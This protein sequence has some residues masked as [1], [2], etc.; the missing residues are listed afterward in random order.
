MAASLENVL[1]QLLIP[2][3]SI[4]QQATQQIKEAFKDPSVVPA[5]TEVLATSADP[6]VRNYAGVLLRR[7]IAK[8][9]QWKAL[10]QEIRHTIKQNILQVLIQE[11]EKQVRNS[12]AQVIG[13]VAK[14]ELD[15][16][17]WPELFQF[18][19][20]YVGC[21]ENPLYRE[22]GMFVLS[23]VTG[24]ADDKLKPQLI[25]LATL[26]SKTLEDSQNPMVPYYSVLALT[27]LVAN[28]GTEEVGKYQVLIPKVL[29]VIAHLLHTDED[30][31][32]EALE[33]FDEL[34]ECDVSIVG[35]HVK[36]IVEFCIQISVNAQYGD[37]IRVKAMSFMCWLTRLKKKAILKHKLVSPIIEAVFPVMCCPPVDNADD[38]D[39]DDDD[40]EEG[41]AS[42]A[43]QV[44]DTLA[45]HIPPEKVLPKVL[46]LVQPAL[47][48]S[49]PYHRKAAYLAMAVMAEGCSEN[50]RNKYLTTVVQCLHRGMQDPSQLVQE[51]ALFSLGQFSEHLEPDICKFAPEILP[52]LFASLEQPRALEKKQSISILSKTYYALEMFCENMGKDILPYLSKLMERLLLNLSPDGSK[53][54][55]ELTISAIAAISNA[56]KTDF[57]PYF[58]A[59]V[60]KLKV[61]LM[62]PHSDEYLPLKIQAIDTLGVLARTVGEPFLPLADEC[63]HLGLKLVDE[64]PDPDLRRCVYGLFAAISTLLKENMAQYLTSM[65]PWMIDSVKSTEGVTVHYGNEE[66]HKYQLFDDDDD[67][68]D[69]G[70]EDEDDD[71][72]GYSV[73]NAFL[74]EKEDACTSLGEIALNS[75]A[76]FL[77]HL[78]S[79]YLEVSKLLDYPASNIRKGAAIAIGN[80]LQFMGK[81]ENPEIQM[82]QAEMMNLSI[83]KLIEIVKTDSDRLVA[84][85]TLEAIKEFLDADIMQPGQQTELLSMIAACVKDVIQMKISCQQ[86]SDDADDPEL[87]D[88]EAEY[89]TML[90][91]Y[92][93]DILPNLA[94]LVNYEQFNPYFR[95]IIPELKKRLKKNSTIS[96]KS[97]AIGVIG[98]TADASPAVAE[99]FLSD[100]MPL[101]NAAISDEDDEVRSNAAYALG[102]V[103]ANAGQVMYSKY[104]KVLHQLIGILQKESNVRVVDNCCAAMCRLIMANFDAVPINEV[105]PIVTSC[106]PLKEDFEENKTV[107][108]CLWKLFEADHSSIKGELPKIFTAIAHVLQTD[109]IKLDTQE[110]LVLM[111]RTAHQRLPEHLTS[112]IASFPADGAAK[113]QAC[114]QI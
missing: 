17:Q 9:K 31:A 91:E 12:I 30:K 80:Y 90:I 49:D 68:E 22:L 104:P 59:T 50:I 27:H 98:E 108:T 4:I 41:A 32:C 62:V 14:H 15:E 87:E 97:F 96:E 76:A 33:L 100:L 46:H 58:T 103:T 25:H 60:E 16:S 111:V 99:T 94:K 26:F 5:L 1:K 45:L 2:N 34:I 39:D 11:N 28:V 75:G 48:H 19:N 73:V 88:D 109:Q 72:Q 40:D 57:L 20:Q 102:V 101:I 7:K 84:M 112:F 61:F 21:S 70:E 69:I 10:S 13:T 67:E 29:Q 44:L 56:A 92:A 55:I 113:L 105:L 107:F 37:N 6:Q 18:I 86:Y 42:Y 63:V 52:L 51:A 66:E 3:N 35:P 110:V 78:E 79:T 77:P 65:V 71:V 93:G 81:S 95:Q 43:A 47:V 85:T 114:L 106:L 36:T 82:K 24:V 8:Q 54:I 64:I 83:P 74:E 89:D 23:K 38:D 53:R